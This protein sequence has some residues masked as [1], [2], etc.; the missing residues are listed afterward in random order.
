MTARISSP[1]HDFEKFLAGR[2]RA[3]DPL[4]MRTL[5]LRTSLLVGVPWSIVSLY[6]ALIGQFDDIWLASPR[7]W[8]P[9]VLHALVF[10]WM[11]FI[12][13]TLFSGG[14]RTFLEGIG[15]RVQRPTKTIVVN[16]DQEEVESFRRRH[17]R[18]IFGRQYLAIFA[19][20]HVYA[21]I[22]D[23]VYSGFSE[24]R[25][26]G[27]TVWTATAN[28]IYLLAASAF[29]WMIFSWSLTAYRIAQFPWRLDIYDRFG[30]MRPF[31]DLCLRLTML[32]SLAVVVS[33]PNALLRGDLLGYAQLVF[34]S[35]LVLMVFLIPIAR[36]GAMIRERKGVVL[37]GDIMPAFRRDTPGSEKDDLA[38]LVDALVKY[39]LLDRITDYPLDARMLGRA[40]VAVAAP[41]GVNLFSTLLIALLGL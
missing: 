21:W 4:S 34:G 8:I 1:L 12:A 30:G 24:Y 10:S 35:A 38:S 3:S 40:S 26:V 14:I 16:S 15:D 27:H 25:Y 7:G 17:L 32:V 6:Q 37:S 5:L 23:P 20:L 19:G 11:A 22:L 9:W 31:V 18:L 33:I 39:Q 13:V 28:E 2:R 29:V 36:L 41:M